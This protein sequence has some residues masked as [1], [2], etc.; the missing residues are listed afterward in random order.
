MAAPSD[1]VDSSPNRRAPPTSSGC[2]SRT[3]RGGLDSDDACSW[4]L[5]GGLARSAIASCGSKPRS[6]SPK[7]SS[8]IARLVSAKYRRSTT[9]LT[10]TT[11]SKRHF[12]AALADEL[13]DRDAGGSHG[14]QLVRPDHRR[15]IIV[16]FNGA[17]SQL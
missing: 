11:G 7:P 1:A 6:H 13:S 12:E 2:G 14:G 9:S 16:I 17:R 15:Q 8:S 5:N 3:T 10:P 4:S